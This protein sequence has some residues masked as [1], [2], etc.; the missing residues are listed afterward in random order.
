MKIRCNPG[1]NALELYETRNPE[2]MRCVSQH[3]ERYRTQHQEPPA[4][5]QWRRNCECDHG[6]TGAH[7]ALSGHGA[8]HEPI[9]ARREVCV[10]DGSLIGRRAPVTIRALEF[11]LI[12]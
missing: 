12:A 4:Q 2:A 10:I 11:V 5:M 3:C 6:G 7:C 9:A 1:A 8:H